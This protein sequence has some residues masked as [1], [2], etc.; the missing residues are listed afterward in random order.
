M[1]D[2]EMLNGLIN[3]KLPK[4]E[5]PWLEIWAKRLGRIARETIDR[6]ALERRRKQDVGC[7]HF[8]RT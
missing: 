6:K 7:L 3:I 1:T 5:K 4:R 2:S 8:Q